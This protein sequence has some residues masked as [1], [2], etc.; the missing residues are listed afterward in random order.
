MSMLIMESELARGHGMPRPPAV[1]TPEPLVLL[2]GDFSI[3]SGDTE[4]LLRNMQH[5]GLPVSWAMTLPPRPGH[6]PAHLIRDPCSNVVISTGKDW[7][8]R[9][10]NHEISSIAH[11]AVSAR[12]L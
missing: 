2:C 6:L 9:Q 8:L 4:E 5:E 1:V 7:V 3:S 10:L 12:R 11:T